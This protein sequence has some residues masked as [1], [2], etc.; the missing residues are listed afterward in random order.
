MSRLDDLY[1]R[2]PTVLIARRNLTR[3]KARTALAVLGIV[4]GV[5]AIASL[6]VFGAVLQTAA[7]GSLGDIGNQV[8][9]SPNPEA[10]IEELTERDVRAIRRASGDAAVVPVRQDRARVTYAGTTTVTTAY[11]I[12]NPD[13]AF[14]ASSGRIPD[15]MRGGALVGATLAENLD[16]RVGNSISVD[17]RSYRV[18]AVLESQGGISP[19]NV[20]GGVVVPVE[21]VNGTGFQQVVVQT[22]TGDEANATAVEIREALNDREERVSIFEFSDIT[23]QIGSFFD[24]LSLFL[25]AIGSISLVVAGVAILNVM[26]MSTIERREEIGVLRAVGYQRGDVLKILLA[27]ASLLGVIGGLAGVGLSVVAGVAIAEV[28]VGDPAVALEPN[29]AVYY[30]AAFGFGVVTSALSG[31]Y[32]AWKAARE[33]PVDALRK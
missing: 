22:E 18:R 31:L 10:G 33:R 2:F 27:E 8:V 24:T 15:P 17:N 19:L 12:E 30:L 29:A 20:G 16:V 11:G 21:S 6:G 26:L 28:A 32:P 9:V 13:D 7:V 3:T 5:V 25:I 23:E 14:A 4:I 1:R